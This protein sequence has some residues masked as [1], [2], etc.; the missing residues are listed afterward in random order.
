VI[1]ITGTA[2]FIV[3]RLTGGTGVAGLAAATTAGNAAAVPM[4]VASAN[5]AYRPVAAQA[6][7]IVASSVLVTAILVPVVTAWWAG[8]VARKQALQQTD[9]MRNA[10]L[11]SACRAAA[12]AILSDEAGEPPLSD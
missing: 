10:V 8:K 7:A 9:E 4:V 5:E 11:S 2:L 3:D 6:T 1:V 12:P